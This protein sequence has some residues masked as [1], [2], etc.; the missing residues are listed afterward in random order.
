MADAEFR[1]SDI[2]LRADATLFTL[3][4]ARRI[5]VELPLPGRHNIANALAAAALALSVDA[6]LTAIQS[7]LKPYS[8]FRAPVPDSPRR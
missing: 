4:A 3:H 8:P 2:V 6:P 7:G 1:A 5:A